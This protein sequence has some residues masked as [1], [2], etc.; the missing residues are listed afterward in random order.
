MAGN[1]SVD[2]SAPVGP[3]SAPPEGGYIPSGRDFAAFKVVLITAMA[4]AWRDERFRETLQLDAKTALREIRGYELPWNMSI[5]VHD[6]PDARWHP[7]DEHADPPNHHQSYW[8]HERPHTLRLFLPAKPS[9]LTCE[10]IALASY[11]AA[12]AEYPFTCCC[13]P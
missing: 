5:H 1:E 6:D 7:P 8:D 9:D 13:A 10:P 2:V 11:N 12:G 4:K 3:D